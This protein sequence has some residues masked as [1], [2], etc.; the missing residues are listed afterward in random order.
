MSP[1]EAWQSLC[2]IQK[3]VQTDRYGCG[4]ACLA[5]VSGTTYESARERFNELGLG[6]RRS[7][8]PAYST[9]GREMHYALA[10]T[11][12]IAES[13]RWKSWDAFQGLGV[14]KVRDDWRGAKGRWHWVVAFRHSAFGIAVFDPH[15]TEPSF[16]EMPL[17]V[18]CFDFQIYQPK[19]TYYQVEQRVAL[20]SRC[21]RLQEN[22][23]DT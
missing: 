17:D 5:M 21:P 7:C 11:G 22:H 18:L 9:S 13:R 20:E 4:I 19:G 2:G 3:V 12:L 16:Q 14:L 15:Q 6:V 10:S 1:I 23:D 8:R